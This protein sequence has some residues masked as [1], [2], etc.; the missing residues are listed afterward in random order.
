[1]LL[2]TF[3]GIDGSGKSTQARRLNEHLQ[4]HGHET[5]LVREPG[6]TE[7]SEQV[8]SILLEPDL[9]VHPMAELL[10]FSAAR[11]QLVT[12]RIRPA[13]EAGQIVICDRF[14]DS[15][16]AYQGAGRNVANPEWLQS[17]HHRVTD[18]LVPT[19]TYLVELD[20]ATARARRTE[21]DPT[22][23]RME[24]EDE[25]FYHRVAAAYDA[26]ADEHPARIH[27]LDGH[28]SIDALHTEIRADVEALLD[29]APGTPHTASGSSS[30]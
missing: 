19:R 25:A 14:Y 30:P 5:L 18:G 6:G 17:F 9:N 3:E 16:T 12:E 13:L 23:D 11:T 2:L 10:L 27:R 24:A 4:E 15:T 20:P 7:L 26:L 8:R 22:D 21:D 29:A 28:R 1:M